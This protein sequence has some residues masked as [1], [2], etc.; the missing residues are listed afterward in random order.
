MNERIV[1]AV[2]AMGGDNAPEVEVEGAVAA[3]RRWKI[4]I[5]LVG[6]QGRLDAVLSRYDLKGLDI[7][8][9]HATEV[10][11]MHDSPSDAVRKK[12]DSSIRV[13]FDLLRGNEVQ[14]VVSA[15]NSGATMAV[16]MFLCKRIPGIDRPAI[17]TILPNKKSQ[18][19]LLDGGANVD[20][21]PFHLS[22]FG[23]MGAVYAKF[24]LGKERPRV[25]VLSNGEEESKG[26]ELAREAH[27][28]LKQSSLNYIGFVEGRDIFSGDVDVVV[29]DGF[30]GNVVLKVSEGLSEAISDMLRGEIKQR[31]FAK[32]G[33][34]LAR[35][36]FRAFK[37][38]V[39]YAEYGGAPL[40]GIQGTGMICHGGSNARA[41]MNAIHMARESVSQR[42]NDRLI[43]QLG[44]ENPE[45]SDDVVKRGAS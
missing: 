28:L 45:L 32:L 25:G 26:N 39:D 10:V 41:I 35:P 7:A 34:L 8:I 1:V 27:K 21:K 13:A 3:A 40:L 22:Q 42:I 9:R 6:D 5:V 44:M 15:G 17:A 2:D 23:T 18:T 29:C 16:G 33:Y 14:A 24:M 31:L 20:C 12:K 30:V 37:K 19:V 36:A 11:G 43:A 4:P 38:K